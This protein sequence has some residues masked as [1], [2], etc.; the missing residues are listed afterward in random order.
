MTLCTF[1]NGVKVGFLA[2]GGQQ[3][4]SADINPNLGVTVVLPGVILDHVEQTTDQVEH[5]VLRV[6]LQT[7]TAADLY[8]CGEC[9]K[10]RSGMSS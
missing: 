10:D 6:V 2:H 3:G 7:H 5:A 8:E 9:C 1:R 4:Q